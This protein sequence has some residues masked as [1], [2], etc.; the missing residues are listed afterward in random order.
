MTEKSIILKE[1]PKRRNYYKI[2]DKATVL[3]SSENEKDYEVQ[4]YL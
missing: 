3:A 1:I 4:L 2:G